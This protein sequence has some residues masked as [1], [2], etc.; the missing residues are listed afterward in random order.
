MRNIIKYQGIIISLVI[1]LGLQLVKADSG[2]KKTAKYLWEI[3]SLSVLADS[4]YSPHEDIRIISV[5]RITELESPSALQII[6]NAFEKEPPRPK[7]IEDAGR[8][9]K[10]Y[11][12]IGIGKIGGDEA[13]AYFKKIISVIINPEQ[14]SYESGSIDF[15]DVSYSAFRGLAYIGGKDVEKLFDQIFN[16]RGYSNYI[17]WRAFQASSRDASSSASTRR[18]VRLQWH[19]S[20]SFSDSHSPEA[21]RANVISARKRSS[22]SRRGSESSHVA[23]AAPASNG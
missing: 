22:G 19:R 4:I 2:F 10:Y 18:R 20:A 15:S 9:V 14:N 5:L 16:N 11:A 7:V 12:L 17:R 21:R 23:R 6:I 13:K 8:G 1:L 3:A